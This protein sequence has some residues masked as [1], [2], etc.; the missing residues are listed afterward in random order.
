MTEKLKIGSH[1]RDTKK[2][3]K[4]VERINLYK[5]A[6]KLDVHKSLD[7]AF[8]KTERCKFHPYIA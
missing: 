5:H 8:G 4:K 6:R 2:K 3:T 7:A 1:R